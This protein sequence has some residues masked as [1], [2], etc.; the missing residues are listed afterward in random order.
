MHGGASFCSDALVAGQASRLA[1]FVVQ[2]RLIQQCSHLQVSFVQVLLSSM[3][4]Q[5]SSISGF[6]VFL[7]A[8]SNYLLS[9]ALPPST[10]EWSE[11]LCDPSRLLTI[12][13]R[14]HWQL[15]LTH[16]F[17]DRIKVN[18]QRRDD[19]ARDSTIQVILEMQQKANT[20]WTWHYMLQALNLRN[21][22]KFW[23]GWMQVL[24]YSNI[25]LI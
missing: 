19:S 11:W 10:R 25:I 24:P 17:D 20:I 22:D 4:P 16:V 5:G 8:G 15:V 7:D 2:P 3:R 12:M 13:S 1:V 6:T 18:E 23:N 21:E 9:S 14:Y